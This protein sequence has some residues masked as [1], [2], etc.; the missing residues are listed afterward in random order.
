MRGATVFGRV[1]CRAWLLLLVGLFGGVG[2][3]VAAA[4][5]PALPNPLAAARYLAAQRA[6]YGSPVKA[7]RLAA[8]AAARARAIRTRP[9]PRAAGAPNFSGPWTPLGPT[10][11]TNSFYGAQNTGRVDSLAVVPS[12]PNAG[13]IFIG[14]AGGGVWSSTDGGK[15]WQTHTDQ[16][17]TGLAIGALAIDPTN[18]S[19]VYAGTGE[20]NNCGDCFYGGGVLKSTD[21]GLTWTVK[22]PGGVFT[23]V[24]FASIAVDPHNGQDLYAGTT[25]GLY[26]STDGGSSW[27]RP[28]G[29]P[30]TAP[31][32]GLV[33]DP[34]KTPTTIYVATQ[35]I[36]VQKSTDGGTTFTTLGGGLPPAASLGV[37]TLGIGTPSTAHPAANQ[38][39]YAAVQLNGTTDPNGGDLS[40]YKST[41]GGTTWTK[42]TIP[43]YTNQSY[44][45]GS[46]S[47]D[48][49]SYD[50]TI[51]VDPADPNHVLA[52]GIA[53]VESTNGGSTWTNVNGGGF[54]SGVT[55][56]VHPDF[57]AL[58]FVSSTEAILG[59][60]GGVYQYKPTTSGPSGV[61]SLNTDQ[62][63][64][65]FYA[66]LSVYNNGAQVLGGLQDN[67]TGLYTGSSAWPDVNSGDGGD[68]AINPLDTKQQFGEADSNLYETSNTWTSL[69]VITPNGAPGPGT[70]FVPPIAL[71]PNSSAP[72]SPTVFYG[73][74]DLYVT[75]NPAAGSPTWTKLTSVGTGVSA[76]G[77]APSNPA[78]MYV[79]FD[80]GTL[81]VSTNATAATPTFTTISPS[82]AQWITHIGVD[83]TNPSSIAV[84]FSASNTQT[85]SEPPMV[86]TGAVTLT[87]TPSATYTDITGNLPTGVASNSVVFD[88]GSLAVA[89]DVGVFSTSSPNG[90][91]TVWTAVGTG[92]P[93]VQV[94]GLT[95]AG[96]GD[97]Y[98]ATHGR[99]V[100][101]LSI[102]ATPAPTVTAISPASGP[103]AG[104][105]SVT[106]TGTDL[107]G[108]TAVEFGGTA[109]T[110]VTVNGPTQITAT[111]PAGAGTVDVTVTTPGGS[112]A[113]SAADQFTYIQPPAVT[114]ISPASGPAAGGTSVT[115]TGTNLTGATA[116]EF[117][118]T[119]A[120][121][122][123][124]NGPT[125]ITATSPAGTGTVDVTVTTPGGSSATSAADQF[126][127]V[128]PVTAPTAQI[129]GSGAFGDQAVNS[130]STPHLL[131]ITN[132]G[133]AALSIPAGGV[134]LS[135]TDAGQY[136]L[137]GDACSGEQIAPG[138]S[139]TAQVS[140][141]PTS[142]GAHDSASLQVSDNAAGS[143]QSL[144]LS[145][146]GTQSSP[147]TEPP[148][149]SGLKQSNR[150]WRLGKALAKLIRKAPKHT[151]GHNTP[152]GTVL[153]FK[154]T[155]K[156]QVKLSFAEHLGHK[157]TKSRGSLT[158][159]APAGTDRIAFDGR[160]SSHKK[161]GP[162]TY[163]VT[164]V[165]TDSA[166]KSSQHKLTFTIVQ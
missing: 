76:I 57:H 133:T 149:I 58:V 72:A 116:V 142:T 101:R 148:A 106:V 165:A 102:N 126:T 53:L 26:V 132:A 18:P 13:E 39:L 41:D 90:G 71:I 4:A 34:S 56:V 95:V 3:S 104:G 23:G 84:S 163:T 140:F 96:N 159:S 94:I 154:L 123:T 144:A 166:G 121:S 11:I 67:G 103:A 108:A 20:A 107:T 81:K 37:T 44:A 131:T 99:G 35:G 69:N 40:M 79:G 93:N 153:T 59:C 32:Y 54:F 91:A 33:L 61:S 136:K 100:W 111:S 46:G 68:N 31:A 134:S 110:S 73:G 2:V 45:Y 130:S 118:G 52:A 78:V 49:A 120:T 115:V 62:D 97:L 66:N 139:C 24:D 147:T 145:G 112:S 16:V 86:Q 6:G 83:P 1:W 14:A 109:A 150:R 152:V 47:S 42:L 92:L 5:R 87:G 80:D 38:T 36:G 65:Q 161:L 75:H 135:G 74:G 43:A 114:A 28:A 8:K 9:M 82:V 127:F 164:I 89:T 146:T 138:A 51:A 105:T 156:S 85:F 124:V 117:G 15:T 141:A 137:A 143:P 29:D 7:A 19:T 60:D 158:L 48:Q 129:S 10:P 17:S 27:A 128:Q 157:R 88:G 63:T 119:A 125:Q 77:V 55:N 30:L 21:G 64:T 151:H 22:N 50:N 98:S 160:L 113:T 155:V 162:G 12:G 70:N 122:V 25:S